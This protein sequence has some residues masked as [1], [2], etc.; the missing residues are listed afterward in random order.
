MANKANKKHKG[1]YKL[2][3]SLHGWVGLGLYSVEDGTTT[4]LS[5]RSH[6]N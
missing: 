3:H 5:E 6:T 2:V 4:F 1:A